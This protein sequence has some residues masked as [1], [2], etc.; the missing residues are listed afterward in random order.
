MCMQA[1][2]TS[3][4]VLGGCWR[5]R[6]RSWHCLITASTWTAT[7]TP[8]QAKICRK[9]WHRVNPYMVQLQTLQL[10]TTRMLTYSTISQVNATIKMLAHQ[11]QVACLVVVEQRLQ[12][13]H[14][15]YCCSDSQLMLLHCKHRSHCCSRCCSHLCCLTVGPAVVLH[16]RCYCCCCWAEGEDSQHCC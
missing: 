15:Q 13:L 6:F 2:W 3:G 5:L 12:E 4:M 8:A 16:S 1:V 7:A 10:A 9:K 11:P 14:H